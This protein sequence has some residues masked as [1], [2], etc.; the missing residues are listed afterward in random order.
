MEKVILQI[1][2]MHCA[3]CAAN[4]E[5]ALKDMPGVKSVN[6]NYANEKAYIEHDPKMAPIHALHQAIKSAGYDIVET[7]PMAGMEHAD[8]EHASHAKIQPDEKNT[9]RRRFWLVLIFG[10]P[11]VYLA[12]SEMIGIE[13]PAVIVKYMLLI[14]L[15]CATVVIGVSI[16]LWR[17]GA[18]S[19]WRRRP[20]MDSLIFIGTATAYFYSLIVTIQ[21]WLRGS[22]ETGM[23]Y[24]ES[25]VFILI[26]IMLGKYLEAITKGR[27]SQAMRQLISLQAT[28]ATL[29]R[30]G[31]EYRVPVAK[32]TVG[33]TIRVKP[34]E[35]IPVDGKIETGYSGV[36]EQAITGESLPVEKREGDSVIGGTM[37]GTGSFTYRATKVGEGTMLAQ[38]IKIVE[39]AMGSKAPIQRLADTAAYYFVP[40]VILIALVTLVVWLLAGNDFTM[41]LTAFVSVL[42]IACPCA[43]GL[44]TPTAIMVGT[45]L[46]AKRGIL[47]KNGQALEQAGRV[48]TVV[49]DKTG[50]L[51]KGR[52]EL[53]N[54]TSLD[55]NLDEMKL[56]QLAASVEQH[57]E[58]PLAAAVLSRATKDKLILA[59]AT[60]FNSIP[61]KGIMAMVDG[62]RMIIGTRLMMEDQQIAFAESAL[63]MA[64]KWETMGQTV[65]FVGINGQMAGIISLADTVKDEA[66]E[67]IRQLKDQGKKTIMITGDN[68]RVGQAIAQQLG[69][70]Q[71]VAQVLPHE[72]SQRVKEMQ[73]SGEIVAMVGDGINDAPALVQANL[74]IVM[75]SGT[76]IAMETG[77]IILMHNDT[78][79]VIAAMELSRFTVSKIKQNL[80]WAFIYN[81]I[82]I[83]IAA[84]V[85]YGLTGWLLSPAIAAA[86]MAGS[87]VSV[88]TNSLLMKRTS[89]R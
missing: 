43:L 84:G 38:I 47:I 81:I 77:D 24:Y 14:Q 49:F 69:I 88:V 76:D 62:H 26:F 7:G 63:S 55:S 22:L 56:L 78:R 42:I 58:H 17:S 12:M 33:D 2:G 4:I 60:E 40:A 87:S 8:D 86:A 10:L 83:P 35:K 1:K 15:L 89:L 25:A 46:A 13:N 57:S 21:A 82:G 19:L 75:R 45:G 70:D 29:V 6:V 3:S 5:H 32:L 52:P 30:D 74:G 11:V 73:D 20:N 44:A 85:L 31:S 65:M 54:I 66:S 50:T 27:T 80:F 59:L 64:A 53:I 9:M 71:V 51:T 79:D 37:N 68:E 48:T 34:G 61:G 72:K 67:A 18:R 41:A 16:F 23:V 39:Q 28:E 36:D